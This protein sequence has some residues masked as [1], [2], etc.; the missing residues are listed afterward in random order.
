MVDVELRLPMISDGC[1]TSA[2]VLLYFYTTKMVQRVE[3]TDLYI[4]QW[5]KTHA[6]RVVKGYPWPKWGVAF[7]T[8]QNKTKEYII[9]IVEQ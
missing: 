7:L 3:N 9:S 5:L 4:G 2:P 8:K 6:A 1:S